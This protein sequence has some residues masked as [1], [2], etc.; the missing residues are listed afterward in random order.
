MHIYIKIH[1]MQGEGEGQR[2]G[3]R[4]STAKA[5]DKRTRAQTVPYH[6]VL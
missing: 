3:Y 6:L 1:I 5:N 2:E 4:R